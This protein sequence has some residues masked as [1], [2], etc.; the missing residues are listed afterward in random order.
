MDA[1]DSQTLLN[2]RGSDIVY[3]YKMI[4][5]GVSVE[6]EVVVDYKSLHPDVK[7]KIDDRLISQGVDLKTLDQIDNRISE[8]KR[9]HTYHFLR[10]IIME[11]GTR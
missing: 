11:T 3:R 1:L 6:K 4:E 5:N 8:M 7:K 2:I 9:K 10:S